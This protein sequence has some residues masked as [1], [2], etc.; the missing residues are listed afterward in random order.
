MA[1]RAGAVVLGPGLGRAE[2]AQEFARGVA[3][4][5][6]APLLVDAD[7]LN[8]HAGRLELFRERDA[9]TVLTPHEA[10]LGR[11]LGVEPDR[12]GGAPRWSTCAR[13]P[14]GAARSCC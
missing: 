5:V 1:E 8:A 11:L 14:S 2:G 6:E 9:P 4:A 13:R 12:G 10:E 7:G 3:A